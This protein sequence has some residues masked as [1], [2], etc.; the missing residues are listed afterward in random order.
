MSNCTSEMKGGDLV[1]VS[2][3]R[4]SVAFLCSIVNI[5]VLT[6]VS[7]RLDK[8]QLLHRLVIYLDV[9]SL[10]SLLADIPQVVSAFCYAPWYPLTC[11]FVGFARQLSSWLLL[12]VG[13]WLASVLTLRYWC[14]NY[15]EALSVGRDAVVWLGMVLLSTVVAAVPLG[16]G[17]YGLNQ[18]RCW[19]KEA[20]HVERW[21]LW[22][23]WTTVAPL[24]AVVITTTA[25]CQSEKRQQQYY[26][27]SRGINCTTQ[28][29]NK[30]AARKL[31][32][33]ISYI[34]IYWAFTTL[35]TLLYQIPQVKDAM[36]FLAT[37]AILEPLGVLI[38][39]VVITVHLHQSGRPR[40]HTEDFHQFRGEGS[41]S[42]NSSCEVGEGG[43]GEKK[44]KS[45]EAGYSDRQDELRESL[46]LTVELSGEFD[47][48]T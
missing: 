19:I 5:L 2:A 20:R 26:E 32:R 22:H 27:S 1:V 21:L 16:T 45:Q 8:S 44:A 7:I 35:A 48:V 29:R 3:L 12:L 9:A 6:S 36:P 47:K 31:K 40:A 42:I 34:A 25:L 41:I 28:E 13:L 33:L 23:G 18:A 15:R 10:L 46:L 14:R 17:G 38:T 37:M 39:P 11:V 43:G 24:V 30:T 4:G